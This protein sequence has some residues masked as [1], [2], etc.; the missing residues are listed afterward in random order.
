MDERFSKVISYIDKRKTYTLNLYVFRI[1]GLFYTL[2]TE[3]GVFTTLRAES[4][5]LCTLVCK[6]ILS[7]KVKRYL[8]K[9]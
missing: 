3:V 1:Q 7:S 2:L 6:S 5:S 4:L 9:K 8:N